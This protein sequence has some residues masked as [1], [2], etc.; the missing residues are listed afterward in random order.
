MDGKEAFEIDYRGDVLSFLMVDYLRNVQKNV[1][2]GYF[3]FR[4]SDKIPI[5]YFLLESV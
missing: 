4:A 1:Y 5:G 3:A 2:L